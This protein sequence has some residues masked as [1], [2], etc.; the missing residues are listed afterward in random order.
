MLAKS[1][2]KLTKNYTKWTI[3]YLTASKMNKKRPNICFCRLFNEMID[4]VYL[5][6]ANR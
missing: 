4:L 1:D 2:F 3:S 6:V 5:S